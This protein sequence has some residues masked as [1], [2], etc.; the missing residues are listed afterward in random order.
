[1][2]NPSP[3]HPEADLG[4]CACGLEIGSGPVGFR[5]DEPVGPVCDGCLLELNRDIGMLM[6]MAHVVREMAETVAATEE[7]LKVDQAMLLLM[8]FAQTYHLGAKWPHRR[9]AVLDLVD[10]LRA[11]IG[12]VPGE[13][14]AKLFT[15]PPS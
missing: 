11:R 8:K 10:E 4:P 6:W 3:L 13:V 1:M 15:T 5:L 2:G 7:P 9:A 12:V 14:W